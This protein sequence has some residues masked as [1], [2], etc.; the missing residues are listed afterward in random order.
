[1][2][3]L[4][5]ASALVYQE[6]QDIHREIGAI[7][8]QLYRS[9]EPDLQMWRDWPMWSPGLIQVV[10][11]DLQAF[12]DRRVT[13]FVEANA[14]FTVDAPWSGYIQSS[15]LKKWID[16]PFLIQP[17]QKLWW[18]DTAIA[19]EIVMPRVSGNLK[20]VIMTGRLLG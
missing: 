4:N 7:N 11:F 15:A 18:Q 1:M 19:T 6:L 5:P 10:R 2:S 3:I 9:G 17:G 14:M 12:N 13:F 8:E 16:L 20:E